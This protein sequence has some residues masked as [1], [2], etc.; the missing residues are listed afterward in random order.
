MNSYTLDDKVMDN[1]FLKGETVTCRAVL[2]PRQ[3]QQDPLL[4]GTSLLII[5]SNGRKYKGIL[6]RITPLTTIADK[7]LTELE[8]S[9]I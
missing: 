5:L 2:T 8:I 9:R 1:A 7:T 3:Q 4:E 6:R